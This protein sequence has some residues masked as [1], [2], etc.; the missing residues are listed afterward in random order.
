MRFIF[1]AVLLCVA[2]P[3][4]LA[5]YYYSNSSK[6]FLGLE[7]G[8]GIRTFDFRSD[9]PELA[10]LRVHQ[11]GWNVGVLFGGKVFQTSFRQG[12]YQTSSFTSNRV[13]LVESE[14][15]FRFHFLQAIA[16]KG[17]PYFK[18][19]VS[20]GIAGH[21]NRLTGT[22]TIP[23]NHG[24]AATSGSS[25]AQQ[26]VAGCTA[27]N[28]ADDPDLNPTDEDQASVEIIENSYL[29]KVVTTRLTA[30][31]GVLIYVPLSRKVFVQLQAELKYGINVHEHGSV[32]Q[33]QN[34]KTSN[35]VIMNFG[36]SA[37]IKSF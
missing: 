18:P 8:I 1:T 34:T 4:T 6:L 2:A 10:S 25:D 21:R 28:S 13:K 27:G 14:L 35:P 7:S 15:G 5:Q 19:Y 30:G 9:I 31:G 33:L 3:L 26:R 11:S 23:A 12:L 36:V 32:Y 22:Y 24:S 20:L 16:P 17:S 29:G 37:G